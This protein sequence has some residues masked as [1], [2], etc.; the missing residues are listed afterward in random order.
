MLV[1]KVSALDAGL[2]AARAEVRALNEQLEAAR[3]TAAAA[4]EAAASA[5]HAAEVHAE[6]YRLQEHQVEQ[7]GGRVRAGFAGK[8]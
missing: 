2:S 4:Q 8:L 5:R 1:A 7:V 3:Q 6:R